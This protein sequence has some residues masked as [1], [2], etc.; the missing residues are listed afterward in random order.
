M[1]LIAIYKTDRDEIGYRAIPLS[2]EY[3]WKVGDRIKTKEGS[4]N[5]TIEIITQATKETLRYIDDFIKGRKKPTTPRLEMFSKTNSLEKQ[6]E[7]LRTEAS[8]ALGK[9]LMK[10]YNCNLDDLCIENIDQCFTKILTSGPSYY[11]RLIKRTDKNEMTL[12]DFM[13]FNPS[14]YFIFGPILAV[15]ERE[16]K[17][18]DY[19]DGFGFKKDE[20][21]YT[22]Q[23]VHTISLES[24]LKRLRKFKLIMKAKQIREQQQKE[25]IIE[26]P[27]KTNKNKL[28]EIYDFLG[29]PK[30]KKNKKKN[31]NKFLTTKEKKIEREEYERRFL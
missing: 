12:D 24:F 4:E 30:S 6:I 2:F 16:Y 15:F 14:N 27:T 31:R 25:I 26:N 8:T 19:S 21:E 5:C 22:L 11:C 9:Q 3:S 20:V 7:E 23:L 17:V 13:K 18:D 10:R 29:K 1:G 28:E